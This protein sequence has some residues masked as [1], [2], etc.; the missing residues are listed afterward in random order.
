MLGTFVLNVGEQCT[1]Y[2]GQM[3]LTFRTFFKTRISCV[4][5]LV[6]TLLTQ[7]DLG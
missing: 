1:E 4:Y 2:W 5:L 7:I 3:Y 6:L